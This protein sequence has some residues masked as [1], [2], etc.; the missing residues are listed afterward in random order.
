M[1]FRGGLTILLLTAELLT[2]TA[3]AEAFRGYATVID[4]QPIE[5]T[6]YV[7]VKRQ[8][9]H[10]PDRHLHLSRPLKSTIG[11]DVREQR[12]LWQ[13]QVTCSTVTD[14]HP[15]TKVTAYRVTYRYRSHIKQTRLSYHP[16]KRLP[17]NVSLSPMP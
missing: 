4:V 12:T 3:H 16:G 10:E 13:A 6:I 2:G 14:A 1:I 9:C 11:E 17:V 8:L 5:E 7:P 15:Q